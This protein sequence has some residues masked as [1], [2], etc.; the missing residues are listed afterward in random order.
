MQGKKVPF[1][2]RAAPFV[3]ETARYGVSAYPAARDV[4]GVSTRPCVAQ[5]GQGPPLSPFDSVRFYQFPS[6]IAAPPRQHLGM[7]RPRHI[8]ARRHL[9]K[10]WI[11]L[12]APE[13][14]GRGLWQGRPSAATA[15]RPT[16]SGSAGSSWQRWPR[17]SRPSSWSRCST[18]CTA[19]MEAGAT[20][21]NRGAHQAS[22]RVSGTPLAKDR[23]RGGFL[24]TY[25]AKYTT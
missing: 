20:C 13:T 18:T 7:P 15:A 10:S 23:M 12:R 4:M 22:P 8:R 3:R 24:F 21:S 25:L 14:E 5:P 9:A 2:G 19:E 11:P 16:D 6:G 17:R 1:T